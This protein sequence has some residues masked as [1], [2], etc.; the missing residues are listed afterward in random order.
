MSM[1]SVTLKVV[2]S[3]AE[4]LSEFMGEPNSVSDCVHGEC[5]MIVCVERWWEIERIQ[6]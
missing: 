1:V 2:W 4:R 3:G 6:R 5:H